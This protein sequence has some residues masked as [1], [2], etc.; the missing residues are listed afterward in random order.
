MLNLIE[1]VD[2][3]ICEKL[4]RISFK[5][6]QEISG[7][8]KDSYGVITN[9][10]KSQYTRVKNYCENVENGVNHV[11]YNISEYGRTTSSKSLQGLPSKI[12]AALCGGL[13]Y[14][15]DIE[16]AVFSVLSYVCKKHYLETLYLDKYIRDRNQILEEISNDNKVSVAEAKQFFIRSVNDKNKVASFDNGKKNIKSAFFSVF[17]SEIKRIQKELAEVYPEK[18]E[19]IC[20]KEGQDGNTYGKLMTTI[21]YYYET[22][23]L[24]E[25]LFELG[26]KDMKPS[27]LSFDGFLIKKEFVGDPLKFESMLNGITEQYKIKWKNKPIN[28]ELYQKIFNLEIISEVSIV[29]EDV[30]EIGVQLLKGYYKGKI[31][32]CKN[33]LYFKT[34]KGWVNNEKT[35]HKELYD[36]LTDLDLNYYCPRKKK[37]IRLTKAAIVKECIETIIKK[38]PVDDNFTHKLFDHSLLKIYFKNGFYDF[39]KKEFLPSDN[40]TLITIQRDFNPKPNREIRK[41]ILKRIF[42]PIFTIKNENDKERIQLRDFFLYKIS[43]VVAGHIEDKEFIINEGFRNCGKG[44]MMDLLISTFEA[45]CTS[46]NAESFLYKISSGDVAKSNSFMANYEFKRFVIMN[47]I[48]NDNKNASILDG[49]KIKKVCSGGDYIQ[50]RTNHKDEKEIRVQACPIFNVNDF[51]EVKPTDALEKAVYFS[52]LSKFVGINEDFLKMPN[53]CYF[54]KDD[55]IKTN[56]ITRDDVKNEFFLMLVDAYENPVE[57]PFNLRKEFLQDTEDDARKLISLF[58]ITGDKT[59]FLRLKD[60]MNIIKSH[61]INFSKS[62]VKK[63]LIGMGA[64]DWRD[65]KSRGLSG[66]IINNE[67]EDTEEED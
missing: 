60:L 11:T 67:N 43:R 9:N 6:F 2:E 5:Q 56:F 52:Y 46:T 16:N 38:C 7:N 54:Q 50:L 29:A 15:F 21:Y 28:A 22:R 47:E 31:I 10:K 57:Y 36:E 25:V 24:Q 65:S 55:S 14:D 4:R 62:K 8:N 53:F 45:Y 40:N 35:I 44:V 23:I 32:Y 3:A 37:Y 64:Q 33:E 12:R 19:K 42:D 61:D 58:K 30:F 48:S 59:D 18:F 49:N 26:E 27:V 34:V 39:K 20:E 66:L 17:D 13:Y 63:Y 1:E 51:P 41:E